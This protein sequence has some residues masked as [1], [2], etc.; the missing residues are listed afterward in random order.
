MVLHDAPL[1]VQA[2]SPEVGMVA[3]ESSPDLGIAAPQTVPS[4]E[5]GP[6]RCHELHACMIA[7]GSEII[8]A[9][10]LVNHGFTLL[11]TASVMITGKAIL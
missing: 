4:F 1:I 7:W 10:I 5:Y 11:H 8:S 3:L 2:V 9:P 6:P